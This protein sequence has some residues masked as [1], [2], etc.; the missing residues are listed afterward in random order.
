[1]RNNKLKK[2]NPNVLKKKIE[3]KYYKMSR[4]C[5]TTKLWF[6]LIES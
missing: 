5:L 3:E 1:M 2:W 4:M 6:Y